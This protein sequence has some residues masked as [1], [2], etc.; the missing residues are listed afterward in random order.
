M[1]TAFPSNTIVMGYNRLVNPYTPTPMIET[2]L[3]HN[4]RSY[5]IEGGED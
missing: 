1:G 3:T 2:M 4:A 5:P